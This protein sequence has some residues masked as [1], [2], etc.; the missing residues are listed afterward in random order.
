MDDEC[1]RVLQL[2]LNPSK[3]KRPRSRLA[4]C[5]NDVLRDSVSILLR[6]NQRK[7]KTSLHAMD[8]IL[9]STLMVRNISGVN[10]TVFPGYAGHSPEQPHFEF[11][12]SHDSVVQIPSLLY[13][14]PQLSCVENES[15]ECDRRDNATG[16]SQNRFPSGSRKMKI[17]MKEKFHKG[18]I[19]PI[20]TKM[21]V[22][23]NQY[24]NER[25][26]TL[27]DGIHILYL[28]GESNTLSSIPLYW[29][30]FERRY[31]FAK[32]GRIRKYVR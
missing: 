19:E 2:R 16:N 21:E 26:N 15:P 1:F 24:M 12:A 17:G 5:D 32:L 13:P 6:T 14:P 8:L 25:S 10:L 18:I 27:I 20:E 9:S 11:L 4:L 3:N 30:L 31:I 23:M 7:G 28:D 29:T 22:S